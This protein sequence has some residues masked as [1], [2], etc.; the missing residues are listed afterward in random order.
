MSLL[1]LFSSGGSA[2]DGFAAG[3]VLA[4][5]A[6]LLGGGATASSTAGAAT[7]SATAS[8][9]AG[10]ATATALAAGQLLTRTISFVP[11]SA[12]GGGGYIVTGQLITAT[13]SLLAGTAYGPTNATASGVQLTATISLIA[14]TA[15]KTLF[16]VSQTPT[17]LVDAHPVTYVYD[18]S[19]LVMLLDAKSMATLAYSEPET[20]VVSKNDV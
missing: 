14:G 3:A 2:G 8:L 5:P 17:V 15:E 9:I 11:G 6:T 18:T 7:N 16:T 4:D 19:I 1:L 10:S 13:S 20:E 12:S